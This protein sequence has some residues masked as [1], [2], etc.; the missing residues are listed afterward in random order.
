MSHDGRGSRPRVRAGS[1]G[2]SMSNAPNTT[3]PLN[4]GGIAWYGGLNSDASPSGWA[5]MYGANNATLVG[6]PTGTTGFSASTRTGGYD[7][8]FDWSNSVYFETGIS[9]DI[10]T[11]AF[12]FKASPGGEWNGLMCQAADDGSG[13]QIR[14]FGANGALA[15]K[16]GATDTTI[17][18]ALFNGTWR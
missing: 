18:S 16:I 4:V 8:E 3:G 11:L 12:W 5:D 10:N 15:V 7:L 13:F 6:T 14:Q 9:A 2:Y 1:E 17:T